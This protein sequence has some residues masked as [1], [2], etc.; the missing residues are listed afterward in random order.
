MFSLAKHKETGS[1]GKLL[2]CPSKEKTVCH[3]GVEVVSSVVLS[4]KPKL[5][6]LSVYKIHR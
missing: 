4:T 3:I 5:V 2:A 1:K 6:D